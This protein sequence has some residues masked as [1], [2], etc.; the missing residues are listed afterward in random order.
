MMPDAR[1]FWGTL[2]PLLVG[3]T[4]LAVALAVLW[5]PLPVDDPELVRPWMHRLDLDHDGCISAA[6]AHQMDDEPELFDVLDHDHSGCLEPVEVETLL[7]HVDP[8]RFEAAAL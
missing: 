2:A 5:M 6:E 1:R 3:F 8:K 7:L 4:G